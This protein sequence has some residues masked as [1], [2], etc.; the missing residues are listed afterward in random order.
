MTAILVTGGTGLVGSRLLPRLVA[1][2]IDCRALVRP[3]KELPPGITPVE[4]DL[5]DPASL[6]EAVDDVTA[7]VHLAAL[8]RTADTDA[9]W[10][11]NRDGTRN[12]IAAGQTH[13]P[14]ARFIM[15]STGFVYNQDLPRPARESD[16]TGAQAAYPASKLVA[17]RQL[18]DSG[19]NW[20]ICVSP[21]ST[22][23]RTVISKQPPA[24]WPSGTG[25]RPRR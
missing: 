4:G 24:C 3:G 25:T 14:E 21:S 16:P 23:T 15:A 11:V 9:I 1:A 6:T 19:L 5:L 7:I 2:G 18:R 20:S 13:A 12:L 17:E 8:F 22:V 10:A